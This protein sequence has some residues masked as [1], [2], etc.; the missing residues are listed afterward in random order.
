[1]WHTPHAKTTPIQDVH[2]THCIVRIQPLVLQRCPNR[3]KHQWIKKN[4]IKGSSLDH[5][6]L[7]NISLWQYWSYCRPHTNHSPHAQTQWQTPPQI[8]L[9]PIYACYQ[10]TPWFTTCEKSPSTQNHNLQT[11][12]QITVQPQKSYQGHQWTSQWCQRMF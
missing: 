7:S 6:H 9:Y 4:T 3:K 12:R 2:L 11:H 10:L 8:R 5:W 1:M